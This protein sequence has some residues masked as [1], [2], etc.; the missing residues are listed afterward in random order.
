M[1]HVIFV[2]LCFTTAAAAGQSQPQLTLKDTEGKAH[3]L[4]DYRG[5]VVV[6]N[7]WA[8]WCVPCKDEMPTF[9]EAQ[10]KY[11][12]RN[13]V[14]L[15]ASLDDARTQKY[16]RKF[17]KTYKMGFPVLL[18]ATADLMQQQF[19]LNDTVPATV[20]LDAQGNI[21]GK[22]EGQARKKDLLNRI[23]RLL[24]TPDPPPKAVSQPTGKTPSPSAAP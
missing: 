16:V 24:F 2:L 1:R 10:K 8:T 4:A 11:A 6:L 7:F 5:K 13:L 21:V 9:V 15:A 3:T 22:I 14:V 12:Q 17:V 18:D 23:A 19:G 20:F